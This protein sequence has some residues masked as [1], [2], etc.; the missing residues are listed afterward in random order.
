MLFTNNLIA[1]MARGDLLPLIVFSIVVAGMLTTMGKRAE[2]ITRLV[3]SAN[4]ALLNFVLL[5]M[6]L[7]PVGI[8]CLVAARFG[9]AQ[10]EGEFVEELRRT[11][12]YVVTVL[13]GLGIHGLVTLPLILWVTTRRNPFRF[14][15][16]MSEAVLTAFSTASSTATLPVAMR[17]AE[18]K[19]G[20]SKRSTEFVLPL[21]ATI[22]MDGTAL[23]EAAAVIF[24]AQAI[25]L[26]LT[27]A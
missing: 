17:C 5:L 1:S 13:L 12:Y 2:T 20:V 15:M 19:A 6:K 24:I 22:D 27:F 8:F 18:K 16:Q 21:G 10:V 9:K 4:D 11:G 26:D 7:A 23:Y 3:A 14:M 25:G